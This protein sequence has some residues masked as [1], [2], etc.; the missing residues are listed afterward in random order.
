MFAQQDTE[1]ALPNMLKSTTLCPAPGDREEELVNCLIIGGGEQKMSLQ[2]RFKGFRAQKVKERKLLQRCRDQIS[3]NGP[4]TVEYKEHLRQKF[5]DQAKKYIGVPYAERFK[6]PD[7]PVA[8]LYL[9]CC[10]LVRKCVQDLQEEFG[11]AIGKWNQ[12]YQMDCLPVVLEQHQ[13]RPGDLIFYEGIYNSNRSKPQKHNNVHVEIFLGGET[14]E[15]TIGSRFHRGNVGI[16]P[17]FK[18]KST[19]WDLVRCHFRSLD[20]WLEGTCKSCCPDHP[21]LSDTLA[22]AAAAGRRSIFND[23]S[24][25]EG[26]GGLDE[27]DEE[28]G[29]GDGDEVVGGDAAASAEPAVVPLPATEPLPEPGVTAAPEPLDPEAAAALPAQTPVPIPSRLAKTPPRLAPAKSLSEFP[30]RGA[31]PARSSAPSPSRSS[32]PSPARPSAPSPS[33]AMP[34][35]R[36]STDSASTSASSPSRTGG[37]VAAKVSKRVPRVSSSQDSLLSTSSNSAS[38]DQSSSPPHTY[39]V[40]NTNGWKLV[41]TAMDKRGWQQLP[42][43]YQFSSRFG[44]KWVERRSQIDYRSHVPGQLVCHIPNN[45]VITTKVGLL[46]SLRDTFCKGPA[47]AP[48]KRTPWVPET[49]LLDSPTDVN[50]LMALNQ[51]LATKLGRDAIW[52]YKPSSNNRGRGIRVVTGTE[53]LNE[54]CYGKDTGSP[55]SSIPKSTGIVQKYI[56]RPLLV[57]RGADRFKF[58]YR[59][60]MLVARNHPTYLAL[61]HPGYCRLTLKPYTDSLESLSDSTVHLTNAAVQKK[62]ALYDGNKDFQIQ[63]VESVAASMEKAGNV[64]GA[65]FLRDDLD[66]QVKRCMVDVLRASTPKF[67]R[68][69]VAPPL[70]FFHLPLLRP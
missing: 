7:A 70:L 17:S 38:S 36:R 19:T 10:A 45:E 28:G 62:D 29:G 12:C 9:D 23:M 31:S 33:R 63:T 15:A 16:F 27:E 4:R 42:F 5:I 6:A 52:I 67:M 53:S 24:D 39:Y 44:L 3:E 54:I 46:Q 25:D 18:F 32:A 26:A 57:P 1:N 65:A 66:T 48:R 51:Q 55:E 40:C 49:F 61:F 30:Q 43:E 64:S 21:W 35:S 68:K 59:C 8:P 50:A 14:G 69:F 37:N 20:P 58:D 11:F 56:E 34:A 47:G 60:Y 13:L 22:I 2:E 41:K